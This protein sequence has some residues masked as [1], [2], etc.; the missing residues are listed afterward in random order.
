MNYAFSLCL[1]LITSVC[2]AQQNNPDK[3]ILLTSRLHSAG[4]FPYTGSLLNNHLNADLNLYVRYKKAGFFVFQSLDLESKNSDIT[5]HQTG[6]FYKIRFS[7]TLSLTPY[8]GYLLIQTQ[9]FYDTGSDVFAALVPSFQSGRLKI[10]NTSLF[11]NVLELGDSRSLANRLQIQYAL[12]NM[13]LSLFL[14]HNI[15]LSGQN[16]SL[17]GALSI[18]FPKVELFKQVPIQSSLLLQTYLSDYKPSYALRRGIV[19]SF[20]FPIIIK[21]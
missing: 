3:E 8:L 21:P 19:F 14:F 10:E 9:R 2:L 20:T 11:T 15:K 1:W 7:P 17:S 6:L 12:N 18:Q 16:P 13:S 4:H 5:Y